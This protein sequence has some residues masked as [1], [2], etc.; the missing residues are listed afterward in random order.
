MR[1]GSTTL[2]ASLLGLL[3][4]AA[5]G[6]SAPCTGNPNTDSVWCVQSGISSGNYQ[7]RVDAREAEARDKQAQVEA[8]RAE[9]ADLE[10]K[11]A[12]S[13]AREAALRSR[14]AAQRTEL[15]RLSEQIAAATR[16]GSL[17]PGESEL[18]R[19]Q[20]ERL[21]QRQAELERSRL[22][23]REMQQKAEALQREIEQLKAGLA[24]RRI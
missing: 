15:D 9:N 12:D 17:T 20:V 23:N 7:R 5:A 21:R 18:Q 19:A 16:A 24:A 1:S 4:C 11:I 22:E 3:A 10:G 13:R 2:R 8:A 6:C 14:L